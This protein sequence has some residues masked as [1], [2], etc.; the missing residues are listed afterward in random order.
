MNLYQR[1]MWVFEL[2]LADPAIALSTSSA[3]DL[4]ASHL[5]ESVP[6]ESLF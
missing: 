5:S 2:T 4:S 3:P 1:T 6:D